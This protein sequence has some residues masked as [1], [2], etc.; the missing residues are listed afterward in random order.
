MP[1]LIKVQ[2]P[3]I[4]YECEVIRHDYY[5]NDD[6]RKEHSSSRVTFSTST[7]IQLYSLLA[8]EKTRETPEVFRSEWQPYTRVEFG[9]IRLIS[10]LESAPVIDIELE[11][12]PE[13][14]EY[15]IKQQEEMALE[16][17]RLDDERRRYIAS[18]EAAEKALFERLRIKYSA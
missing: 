17:K 5:F 3:Y 9:D 15:I 1:D 6:N 18:K 16:E 13:W 11:K 10:V 7:K 14:V 2:D 12:T 4:R 8:K